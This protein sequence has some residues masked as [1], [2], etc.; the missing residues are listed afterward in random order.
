MENIENNNNVV[1][2]YSS[3]TDA[4]KRATQKYRNA[5]RDKVN[6]QRKKYYKG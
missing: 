6:E 4:Q 5:N 1:I 3:Y 2:K